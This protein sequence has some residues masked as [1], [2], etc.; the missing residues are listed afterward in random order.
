M[1][2]PIFQ[3]FENAQIAAEVWNQHHKDDTP[4]DPAENLPGRIIPL[5]G[6]MK[7]PHH[8]NTRRV[9][10]IHAVFLMYFLPLHLDK[11]SCMKYNI[12]YINL[13]KRE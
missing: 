7:K 1:Y 2:S 3:R 10:A 6:L 4:A 9:S 11:A 5:T 8:C 13:R 12:L